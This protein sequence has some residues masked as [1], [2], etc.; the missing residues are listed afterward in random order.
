M[1]G[2]SPFLG[3]NLT[4]KRGRGERPKKMRE[5]DEEKV[6]IGLVG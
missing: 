6:R 2:Q 1:D 3:R 5:G 4:W